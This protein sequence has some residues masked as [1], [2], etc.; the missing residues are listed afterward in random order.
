MKLIDMQVKEYLD[1]L[2][3]DAPAPGGGSVS[4][5]AGAQGAAL[6]MM[7]ADLTIG[8]EKY[9]DWQEVCKAAKEKGAA[10]Y[11]ELTAAVDKDTEAFNLVSA[12]FKMPK[13]TDEEKAARKQAIADGTLVATEVPFR[14]MQL[15]YEGLMTARTM[16]GKSNPNAASDLGVAILNL[17]ACIKGAW[18]NVK[19]NLP[20]VKDGAKAAYYA[21]EGQKMFDEADKIASGLYN[22]VAAAL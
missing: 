4:A 5:L 7:V 16:I 1:V 11:E 13:E 18:L 12:A 22:E 14:T 19:I 9:A 20:G 15:G 17:T 6:F 21:Q 2:K 10:L 3:S 8:K